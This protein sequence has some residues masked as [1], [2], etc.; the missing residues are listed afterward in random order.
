MLTGI[1]ESGFRDLGISLVGIAATAFAF[2]AS[3]YLSGNVQSSL[4][5]L[6]KENSVSRVASVLQAVDQ[7]AVHLG[8]YASGYAMWDDAYEYMET[9]DPA[10]LQT[11][12]AEPVLAA[13]PVQLLGIYKLDGTLIFSESLDENGK[14]ETP[15]DGLAH[16]FTLENFAQ[17]QKPGSF[18]GRIEWVG[19]RAYVVTICPITD[20][21]GT[22]PIR[23]YLFFATII[24]EK[25]LERLN[26]LT[27]TKVTVSSVQTAVPGDFEVNTS[28]LGAAEVDLREGSATEPPEADAVFREDNTLQRSVAFHMQLPAKTFLTGRKLSQTIQTVFLLV[29]AAFALFVALALRESFRWRSEILRRDREGR[30]IEA[31]RKHAEQLADK[32]EAADRAKSAF[33][34]M[35]SHEIRTPLN[36]IIGYANLLRQDK[37]E[38]TSE[39]LDIIARNGST[40]QRILDDILDFSKIEADKLP[41]Q[42]RPTRIRPLVA[43]LVA[44]FQSLAEIKGNRV[45]YQ[46]APDLPECIL[47]DDLR[48]RQVLG[49]L[50]SNAVKFSENGLINV[51]ATFAAPAPAKKDGFVHF[52][53]EDEGIGIPP[54]NEA[55][56]F[57]AFNQADA[58]VARR[59]GGTGLGLAIC[60]RLCSLMGGSIT[61]G[62]RKTKGSSF[63]VCLPTQAAETVEESPLPRLFPQEMHPDDLSILVVDDNPVNARLLQSVLKRLGRSADL[64]FSGQDAIVQFQKNPYDMVFM[65]IH[66]PGLDGLA[67]A[68]LLREFE[69]D[70]GRSPSTIVAVTADTLVTDK[71]KSQAAG[72]DGHINKPIK[73]SEI[74]QALSLASSRKHA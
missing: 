8:E 57:S 43:D 29:A 13:T 60:Q 59:H 52:Q 55:A 44:T 39:R 16:M 25:M 41:I 74:E 51:S 22:A 10:F 53:V 72:M 33:L 42:V 28:Y 11:N 31:A 26:L 36:A 21:A 34:A 69:R 27:G 67:A 47:I 19:E 14:L 50:L 12:Y 40:L 56:L 24:G 5:Q 15:P 64:A 65:D 32:A 6:Q 63:E 46:I 66:M 23:G 54:E 49:N 38:D 9:R 3:L 4:A 71:S 37:T 30:E 1:K 20:S 7:N 48:V 45:A 62:R 35:I 73:V 61:Y 58:S 2:G 17:I 70:Q 68:R 18:L